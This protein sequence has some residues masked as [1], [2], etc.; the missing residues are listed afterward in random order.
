MGAFGGESRKYPAMD[1]YRIYAL[2]K[3]LETGNLNESQYKT[4]YQELKNKC[5]IYIKGA[6]KR[7][8]LKKAAYYRS[9]IADCERNFC[10][11]GMPKNRN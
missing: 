1:K 2:K 7:K 10:H 11:A 8:D 3:I 5:I 6:L 4:A 9:L